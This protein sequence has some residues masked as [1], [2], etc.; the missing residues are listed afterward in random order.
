[1]FYPKFGESVRDNNDNNS[2]N[3][4]PRLCESVAHIVPDMYPPLQLQSAAEETII[5][6]F[7]VVDLPFSLQNGLYCF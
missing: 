1:M 4:R 6:Y 5:I 7:R 3:S 2:A